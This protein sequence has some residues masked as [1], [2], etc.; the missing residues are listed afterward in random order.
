MTIPFDLAR[1]EAIRDVGRS[2]AAVTFDGGAQQTKLTHFGK[3]LSMEDLQ[4]R[5]VQLMHP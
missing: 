1:N 5:E 4:Q 3:N 2:S